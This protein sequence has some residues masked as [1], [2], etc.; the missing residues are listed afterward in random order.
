MKKRFDNFPEQMDSILDTHSWKK[1][2]YMMVDHWNYVDYKCTNCD[3]WV[4][5]TSREGIY[6]YEVEYLSC[7]EKVIK[8]IIE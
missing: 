6:Y 7:D 3:M 8:D 4:Y 1:V 5:Q 2:N